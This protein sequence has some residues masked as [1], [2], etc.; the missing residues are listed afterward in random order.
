MTL[1]SSDLSPFQK[2][3]QQRQVREYLSAWS[4]DPKN[5][6]FPQRQVPNVRT[7]RVEVCKDHHPIFKEK[8][9][10]KREFSP[11]LHYENLTNKS[12]NRY[13]HHQFL[14]L[15][16]SVDNP[17]LFWRICEHLLNRSSSFAVLLL[18]SVKP[19]WHRTETYGDIWKIMMDFRKIDLNLYKYKE[20]EIP[21]GPS[22]VRYLGVPS[23]HWRLYLHGLQLFLQVWLHPYSHPSQHG[24]TKHRGT[25]SAWQQLHRE[26]LNSSNIYEYDLKQFFDSVNLD[27]LGSILIGLQIPSPLVKQ[28][29]HWNRTAPCN[30]STRV[31]TW[32]S[33][34]HESLDHKYHETGTYSIT[35]ASEIDYW[36]NHKRLKSRLHQH[37]C[38]NRYSYYHGVAQG[39]SIS[40]LLSTLVLTKDLLLNPSCEVVQYADDGLLYNMTSSPDLI[41]NFPPESGIEVHPTKSAWVRRDGKWLRPLKFLGKVFDGHTPE[42]IV[43]QGGSLSNAT[44][45]PHP[46]QFEDYALVL[47]ADHYDASTAE[48]K[49][50]M[51]NYPWRERKRR[52]SQSFEEWFT[53]KY[54]GFITARLYSG[55]LDLESVQQ[56]FT[57]SFIRYSWTALD[58][59]K[60]RVIRQFGPLS[61]LDSVSLTVFNSSSFASRS[62]AQRISRRLPKKPISEF[63]A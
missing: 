55:Q 42:G 45:T 11:V 13:I 3:S 56:D 10:Y 18:H 23:T 2:E 36:L 34:Y 50:E 12:I 4:K 9:I 62:L 17:V 26:V 44:R 8:G 59:E 31:Q 38:L 5:H 33:P 37:R 20:R 48:E 58:L 49:L 21:K 7:F 35:S 41:L 29:Q 60:K 15:N 30:T 57:L 53:S 27:Y 47:A 1:S 6:L 52:L 46:F 61:E 19:G 40:P 25:D 28:I 39:S 14:R 43:C 24:Y 63:Q 54:Y 16:K 51:L 32:S 22:S